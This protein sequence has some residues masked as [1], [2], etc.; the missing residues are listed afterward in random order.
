M[1]TRLNISLS[2]GDFLLVAIAFP[3]NPMIKPA[4]EK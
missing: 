3:A 4:A 1:D 2:F